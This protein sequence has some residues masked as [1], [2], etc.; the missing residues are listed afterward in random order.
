MLNVKNYKI[1]K[2]KKLLKSKPYLIY[3]TIFN[4]FTCI[5]AFEFLEAKELGYIE[6]FGFHAN[7]KELYQ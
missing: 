4:M 3:I 6:T 2:L 7:V 1:I 5:L